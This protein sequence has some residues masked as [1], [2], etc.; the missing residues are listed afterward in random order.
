MKKI[1]SLA[2]SFGLLAIALGC[3]KKDSSIPDWPWYDPSDPDEWVVAEGF[4]TLPDYIQVF[5][6]KEGVK[7][8]GQN[9]KAFI[10]VVD[11]TKAS[12]SVWGLNDPLLTGSPMPLKTP[13]EVY[14]ACNAPYIVINGG[15]F[16]TDSGTQYAASVAVNDGTFLSPNINYASEDWVSIYYPTRAAFIEHSNG[17]YEAA[18]T[19]WVDSDNHFVYQEP[20]QNSWASSPLAQPSATFPSEGTP[21][22]AKNAIGGGPVLI[23]N[24]KIVNTYVE[25]LFNGEGS[26]ILVDTRHPRTAIGITADKKLVLFVC[27]GRQAT[28]GIDGFTTQEVAQILLSYGCVDAINL[29]GGG[30]SCMLV[31]GLE[32]IIPSDTDEDGSHVE[33]KVGSCVYIK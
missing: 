7:M 27:E 14:N 31:N 30:S 15:F 19:Y 10:A 29:D 6:S 32:T 1:F 11:A 12:F 23:K 26:G 13:T 3:T 28:E 20:A 17:T 8:K 21:F 18:W 16:Y 5:R 25:E 22:E 4:G 24:G 33:R 9:V 2:I